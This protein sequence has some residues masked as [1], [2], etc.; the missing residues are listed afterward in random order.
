M[1]LQRRSYLQRAMVAAIMERVR[2]AAA[3]SSIARPP[4]CLQRR[5]S[6]FGSGRAARARA[7]MRGA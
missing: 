5:L 4:R 6:K 2:E 1:Q 7:A 3:A